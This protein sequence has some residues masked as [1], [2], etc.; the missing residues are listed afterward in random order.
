MLGFFQLAYCLMHAMHAAWFVNS[1]GSQ[2]LP[3]SPRASG[4]LGGLRTMEVHGNPWGSS[5]L[6]RGSRTME[7]S[8]FC[9]GL[10]G[11]LPA[12]SLSEPFVHA[13][14]LSGPL[15]PALSL[16][17][18]LVP[19]LSLSGP[20]VPTLGAFGACLLVLRFLVLCSPLLRFLARRGLGGSGWPRGFGRPG[21]T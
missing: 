9:G 7:L 19:A 17:E 6:L 12:F 13:F 16:L 10:G 11:P 2:W 14:S 1:Q 4:L 8:G 3:R 18:P 20:S 5:G 15:V 21:W